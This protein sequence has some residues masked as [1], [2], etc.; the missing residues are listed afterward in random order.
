VPTAKKPDID[1]DP[2]A[3]QGASLTPIR[4]NLTDNLNLTRVLA[5]N[6]V[7]FTRRAEGKT[8]KA[9]GHQADYVVANRVMIL[10]GKPDEQ[11]WMSAEGKRSY[12][13]RILFNTEDGS[14]NAEGHTRVVPEK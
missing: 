4:I 9:G 13:D 11:P 2:F 5:Q 6:Q 12:A 14:M 8:Q 1:A 10:T 3:M 7:L